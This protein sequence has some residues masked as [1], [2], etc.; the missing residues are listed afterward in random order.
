MFIPR[1]LR[2]T[3]PKLTLVPRFVKKKKGDSAPSYR[4]LNDSLS[5]SVNQQSSQSRFH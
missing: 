3:P 5:Y 4:F 1:V 2:F